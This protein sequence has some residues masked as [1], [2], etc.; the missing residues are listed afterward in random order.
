MMLTSKLCKRWRCLKARV[1]WSAGTGL[2]GGGDRDVGRGR[3]IVIL[4][5]HIN[6]GARD[7]PR[8][9]NA[10]AHPGRTEQPIVSFCVT[11]C[12]CDDKD[13]GW[14]R[15]TSAEDESKP[16]LT[17]RSQLVGD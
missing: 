15:R 12:A 13:Q 16:H 10:S 8:T 4:R 1:Y 2:A 17:G 5:P 7:N 3:Y 9:K 14:A 11:H 6:I